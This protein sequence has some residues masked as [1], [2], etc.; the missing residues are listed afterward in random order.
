MT[1]RKSDRVRLLNPSGEQED[2]SGI[3]GANK[4][5]TDEHEEIEEVQYSHCETP[6]TPIPKDPR[7]PTQQEADGSLRYA[8]YLGPRYE[9]RRG[10]EVPPWNVAKIGST[11]TVSK[12]YKEFGGEVN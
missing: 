5:Q 10:K 6:L 7:M 11:P 2:C 9:P 8:S 4:T 12:D 3:E 1:K